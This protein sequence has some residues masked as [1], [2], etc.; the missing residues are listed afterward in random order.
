VVGFAAC[1]ALADP[2]TACQACHV[3]LQMLQD[4]GYFTATAKFHLHASGGVE[5]AFA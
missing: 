5:S 2:I 1:G 3:L 4:F